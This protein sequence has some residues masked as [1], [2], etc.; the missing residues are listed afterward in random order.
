MAR[1]VGPASLCALAVA[2]PARATAQRADHQPADSLPTIRANHNRSPAGMLADGVLVLDLEA[3]TG[4]WYPEADDGV[5]LQVMAFRERGKPLQIPGPLIRAPL[6]TDVRVSI[7]NSLEAPLVLHGFVTSSGTDTI[8]VAAGDTRH[9]NSRL[10]KEGT[11]HYWA[12]STNST[13]RDRSGAET[14]LAGAIVVDP[15]GRAMDDRVFVMTRWNELPDTT[16]SPP[17]E[18]RVVLAINGKSWPFTERLT[19][20]IGDSV[21]WRW[22]NATDRAHPMHL[23]GYY[24]RVDAKGDGRVDSI[25]QPA[26]RRLAVTEDLRRGQTATLSWQPPF[27]P[28]NWLFH[29]HLSFHVSGD[30][31]LTPPAPEAET[32]HGTA[33]HMAGLVL[34]VHV[35]PREGETST[36]PAR[37][38]PRRLRLSAG[39]VPGRYGPV[40]GMGFSL[41]D[42]SGD[43]EPTQHTVPGPP[44]VLTRG[45]PV[46]VQV[47]NH[48][49]EPTSIHWHGLELDSYSDG[50]PDWSGS[51]TRIARPIAPGDSFTAELTL[52]RAGT[53]IYHSHLQDIRQLSRGLYG[54][55][56]ILEPGQRF[57]P[58]TDHVFALGWGGGDEKP[59][60]AVNGDSTPPP[61]DLAAGTTHRL[62]FLNIA[63][64]GGLRVSLRKDSIPVT[65][66]PLAK[67][68]ADLPPSQSTSRPAQFFIQVGETADFEFTP[69]SPGDYRLRVARRAMLLRVR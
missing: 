10:D 16:V 69:P 25:Y 48:L 34:G 44:L 58:A 54:A 32:P 41:P 30:L 64:A 68:G 36:S 6:G 53:F 14:Q 31:R 7:R 52:M 23:H 15:P 38:T 18:E 13:L 63:P 49:S 67:D 61:L 37:G 4:R 19:Y 50:V 11:L 5:G 33:Q 42:D 66:R 55:I 59:H 56:V 45:A 39:P 40:D 26:D 3:A 51:G 27:H 57:D 24:F 47:T 12:S 60:I 8:H 9:I 62:R 29:C 21:H 65:W 35:V 17:T 46:D 43:D 28:G 2:L 20:E 1:L 22:I